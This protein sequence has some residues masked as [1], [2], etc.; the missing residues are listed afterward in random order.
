MKYELRQ[1]ARQ[2]GV[3]TYVGVCGETSRIARRNHSVA[4]SSTWNSYTWATQGLTRHW[5]GYPAIFHW[6]E[7]LG[8]FFFVFFFV[9]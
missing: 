4:L 9:L 2:P 6:P 8:V 7:G 3:V 5:L 1:C